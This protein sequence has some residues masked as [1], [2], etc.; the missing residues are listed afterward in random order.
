MRPH[1]EYIGLCAISTSGALSDVEKK[2]LDEHVT[3]CS[4]CRRILREY[5]DAAEVGTPLFAAAAIEVPLPETNS[6]DHAESLF[7]TKLERERHSRIALT[8][9]GLD[10]P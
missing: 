2:E 1:D 8:G 6:L 4:S 9:T 7:R 5:Q 10:F 3:G